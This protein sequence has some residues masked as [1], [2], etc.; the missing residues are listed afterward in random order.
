MKFLRRFSLVLRPALLTTLLTVLAH[1]GTSTAQDVQPELVAQ[2]GHSARIHALAFSADGRWL[3]AVDS[4]GVHLWDVRNARDLRTFPAFAS[5]VIA[6]SADGKRL[7]VVDSAAVVVWDTARASI[8]KKWPINRLLQSIALGHD[9]RLVAWI[10]QNNPDIVIHDLISDSDAQVFT[11]H[12]KLPLTLSFSPDDKLLASASTEDVRTFDVATGAQCQVT[13]G[14]TSDKPSLAFSHDGAWL[15]V[16]T[17]DEDVRIIEAR[18]GHELEHIA[19]QGDVT[20]LAF[21]HDEVLAVTHRGTYAVSFWNPTTKETTVQQL[22]NAILPVEPTLS[23]D[24]SLLVVIAEDPRTNSLRV[25]DLATATRM[26]LLRGTTSQILDLEAAAKGKLVASTNHAGALDIWDLRSGTRALELH[27]VA[28]WLWADALAFSPDGE[29]LAVSN[30]EI[31]L[32]IDVSSGQIIRQMTGHT[33]SIYAIAFRPDGKMIATGADDATVRLWDAES[34][35]AIKRMVG[36]S[37]YISDVAFSPDGRWLVSATSNE[38]KVWDVATGAEHRT[39]E[40]SSVRRRGIAF[41]PDGRYLAATSGFQVRLIE[42]ATGVIRTLE[43]PATSEPYSFRSVLFT[44]KGDILIVGTDD[45]PILLLSPADGRVLATLAG[46]QGAVKSL[47]LFSDDLVSKDRFLFS[48]GDDGTLMLWNLERRMPRATMISVPNGQDWLVTTPQGLFDGS[49]GGWTQVLWRF[50]TTFDVLPVEAF[51]TDFYRPGL[52]AEVLAGETPP[53]RRQLST[54]DRRLPS[55]KVYLPDDSSVRPGV[56]AKT[57]EVEVRIEVNAAARDENHPASSGARDLR[58]F[59]NGSL[60]RFWRGPVAADGHAVLSAKLPIVAGRN[61]ITAYAFNDQNIKS[62]DARLTITGDQ[63]IG[64][65]ATAHILAIGINQYMN[66]GFDLNFANPDAQS[67]ASEIAR[68]LLAVKSVTSNDSAILLDDKAKRA[69][70]VAA[71]GALAGDQGIANPQKLSRAQPEDTIVIYFAG[72]GLAREGKFYLVPHDLGYA[73]PRERFGEKAVTEVL[74]HSIS[75]DDLEQLLSG[76]DARHIVLIIDACKSGEALDSAESRQGPLNSKGLAQLAYDKGIYVLT[77]AYEDAHEPPALR[78]GLLTYALEEALTTDVADVSPHDGL[79]D[80][81][82]WMDYASHRVPDLQVESMR[83]ARRLGRG[84]E[85][86]PGEGTGDDRGLLQHPRM[87]LPRRSGA[88][89]LIVARPER[90]PLVKQ[91]SAQ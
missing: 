73:G 82:E 49:E 79:V 34:G 91:E 61:R 33:R 58:L 59:R 22:G 14:H 8:V 1:T 55:V 43:P 62:E 3:A 70:I 69:D 42:L 39:I 21:T 9:G 20:S 48:G 16:P 90:K 80:V 10:E 86:L 65:P 36:H 11:G 64:L 7:A 75:S 85:L 72:H 44:S 28:G 50:G 26:P 54:V 37:T 18:S 12:K 71:I 68:E 31:L 13:F 46:H 74:K 51:F 23:P 78:H 60:V 81:R 66:H 38:F 76:I 87:F 5:L 47:S 2:K 15:A 24:A 17:E 56:P 52:L 84:F 29:R 67:L 83:G 57:R 35:A 41:S 40:G 27:P 88:D 45:G 63:S 32:L 30:R 4:T 6:I 19:G 25:W 53:P 77:A 89:L